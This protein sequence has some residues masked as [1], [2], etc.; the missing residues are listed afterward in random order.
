[1]LQGGF[2]YLGTSQQGFPVSCWRTSL[3]DETLHWDTATGREL[4]EWRSQPQHRMTA[5]RQ[6]RGVPR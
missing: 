6:S 4:I 1:M 3:A 5:D 2:I